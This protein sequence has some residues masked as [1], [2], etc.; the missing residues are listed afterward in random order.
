MNSKESLAAKTAK[1]GAAVGGALTATFVPQFCD[2]DIVTVGGDGGTGSVTLSD[3]DS[4]DLGGVLVQGFTYSG[5]TESAGLGALGSGRLFYAVRSSVATSG[6]EAGQ[7]WTF[8][9]SGEGASEGAVFSSDDNWVPGHFSVNGVNNGNFIW[10]WLQVEL[11]SSPGSFSPRIIS[12]TYDDAA[13]SLRAFEKPRGGFT[14]S[15]TAVP[16]PSGFAFLALLAAG[17]GGIRRYRQAA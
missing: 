6:S 2:A 1:Y 9:S 14:V 3:G 10:G 8:Y 16:E 7:N 5:D 12:F 11:G 15:S 4:T 13:T 17:A